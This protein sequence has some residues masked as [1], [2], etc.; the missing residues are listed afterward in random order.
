MDSTASTIERPPKP[1]KMPV[2]VEQIPGEIKALPRWFN[3]A[4]TWNEK[5]LKWDKPPLKPNGR[6]AKSND[7]QTWTTFEEAFAATTRHDGVGFSLHS[8]DYVGI[9]LDDCRDPATGVIHEP[10]A[11]IIKR[12]DTYAEVSPSGCGVK[13]LV[14]AKLPDKCAKVNHDTGVEVYNRQYF[15][16]TGHHLDGTPATI[17]ERQTEV[18]W[19][20]E[21]WVKPQPKMRGNL[22]GAR[23]DDVEIARSAL[24]ALRGDRAEVYDDWLRV[25][26]ALKSVSDSLLS[27]WDSW[28]R[29]SSKYADGVCAQKWQSFNGHGVGLG[30]LIHWAKADGWK[31]P[32]GVKASAP[33]SIEDAIAALA[34]GPMRHVVTNGVKIKEEQEDGTVKE[35]LVALSMA[36]II[37][38][39]DKQ[40]DNGIRR[41]D[42]ALFVHDPQHGIGWLEKPQSLFG[43]LARTVGKVT[44][45]QGNSMVQQGQ[46]FAEY[47]RT[48]PRFV[49]VESLPHEPPM[50]G[51]YYA[52]PEIKPGDGAAL[53][54]LLA[55]FHPATAIDG[56]LI[57]SAFLTP[58]WGG[59]AGCRPCYVITS[60]DGRGAGKS[61]LAELVGAVYDGVLQFSHLEDIATIKT[62]LLS[63][64]ALTRRVAVIDN[65]KSHKFSWGELEAMITASTIGGRRLYVGEATR[66]NTLTWFLTLN[67]AALSSDMAQR[68]IIVKVTKPARSATWFEETSGYIR[69]HQR[70][71]LGDIIAALRGPV[72]PLREFTRWATWE[73]DILQRLPEPA[74]AQKVIL[75]RQ[76][77]VDVDCEEADIIEE[78]F[79]EQ[80][81]R[82]GY[83]IDRER[84]FL[85]SQ[86]T[87]RWFGWATNQRDVSVISASRQLSQLATEGRLRRISIAKGRS[88]TRGRGFYFTGDDWPGTHTAVDVLDRIHN[89]GA[90]I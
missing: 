60:D 24:A 12:L 23:G 65:I 79:G 52:C 38:R 15:T 36:E 71:I 43:W 51:H 32:K 9:D 72:T 83:D 67:G 70:A 66:P 6:N 28:S 22:S 34:E 69:E 40:T 89:R 27:D 77:A 54:W 14:K 25:G 68:S 73:R 35:K 19:L 63:P 75:E 76:A 2:L 90:Q 8:S 39:T 50:Q 48:A 21:T 41:V 87:A 80:L 33:A 74:D 42:G 82:L 5:A 59:P 1:D 46:L 53:R 30:T 56:D 4:W 78:H 84:V 86:T 37:E 17:N 47:Q 44:W 85:P 29:Q 64:E 18:E 57:L 62:R 49:S 61:T 26:M 13:L 20:L 45:H 81:T 31:P 55:R 7:P 88:G 58:L 16:I 11:S 3:W 10:A